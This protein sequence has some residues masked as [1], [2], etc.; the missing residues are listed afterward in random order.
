MI[1]KDYCRNYIKLLS[2][3]YGISYYQKHGNKIIEFSML[4]VSAATAS[5]PQLH[6]TL[7]DSVEIDAKYKKVSTNRITLC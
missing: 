3:F 1:L 2:F 5:T 4:A 6:T 7:D